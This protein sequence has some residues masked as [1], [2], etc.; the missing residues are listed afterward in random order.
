[1]K[2]KKKLYKIAQCHWIN[3]QRKNRIGKLKMKRPFSP[4][5]IEIVS[6]HTEEM[7]DRKE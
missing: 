2:K 7:L 6:K 5:L 1:M 3:K 4:T